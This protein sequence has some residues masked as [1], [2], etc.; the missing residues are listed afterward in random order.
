MNTIL[1]ILY[2]SCFV[3]L[4][5]P[6]ILGKWGQRSVKGYSYAKILVIAVLMLN[7][8]AILLINHLAYIGVIITLLV[9]L[10]LV[11]LKKHFSREFIVS[12]AVTLSVSL[13]VAL[14]GSNKLT[15][16]FSVSVVILI[17]VNLVGDAI[18][19]QKTN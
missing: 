4:L 12:I 15:E 9:G 3:I 17:I 14:L 1:A 5:N 11:L 8:A 2:L 18:Y 6:M 10:L 7:C 13:L 16:L 19:E